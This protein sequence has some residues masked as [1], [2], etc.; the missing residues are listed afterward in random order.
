MKA[1]RSFFG[2]FTGWCAAFLTLIAWQVLR[3]PGFGYVTD[4]EFFLAWPA[5][6]GFIGWAIFVVPML[7]WLDEDNRWLQ[8]STIWASGAVYGIVVFALLVCW[9][10]SSLM[11]LAWFPA[12]QGGVGGLVYAWLGRWTWPEWNTAKAMPAFFLGPAALLCL[13]TFVVWP[14]VV[15]NAPYLAYQFGADASRAAAHLRILGSIKKGDTFADLQRRYPKL[16]REPYQS[17]VGNI[18]AHHSFR[19]RFDKTSTYVTEIS[20]QTKP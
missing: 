8:P 20:I 11:G 1:A 4:F 14:L 9:W 19:I 10:G 5:I 13:F 3:L 2:M 17:S 18:D 15:A 16:F 7:A 6:F 12:I